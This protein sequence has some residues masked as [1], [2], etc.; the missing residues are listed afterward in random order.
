[1]CEQDAKSGCKGTML[2]FDQVVWFLVNNLEWFFD[3]AYDNSPATKFGAFITWLNGAT[4][5]AVRALVT[6]MVIRRMMEET[7][8]EA[9]INPNG[10]LLASYY[11]AHAARQVERLVKTTQFSLDTAPNPSQTTNNS[12]RVER[13]RHMVICNRR[14]TCSP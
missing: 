6:F 2:W 13:Q 4:H 3:N 8:L 7:T 5:Q 12:I 10:R 9:T 1:M 14:C 11:N